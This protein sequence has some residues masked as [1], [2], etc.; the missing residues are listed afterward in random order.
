MLFHLTYGALDLGAVTVRSKLIR[1][2]GGMIGVLCVVINCLSSCLLV[3][4]G[5]KFTYS[6]IMTSDE[7]DCNARCKTC[8]LEQ[9]AQ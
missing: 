4:P 3:I 5:V 8:T 2:A 6:L 7:K 1:S 9:C